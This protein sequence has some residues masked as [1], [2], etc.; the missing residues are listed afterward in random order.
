MIEEEVLQKIRPRPEEEEKLRRVAERVLK[1]LEGLDARLEGSFRKGTWLSGDVDL[2][3]FV[4]FPKDLGKEWLKENALKVLLERL[5]KY[6]YVV[7]YA[8]HP[9]L[10]LNVDGV[11]VEVVPALKV[12]S[13]EEAITPV[14]RTP[15]HTDFV[16]RN[17][18]PE[19]R[20]EVRLLK[21]FMKGI[22]VYGAEIK[23]KGFSGYVAELLVYF[24]GSFR[25]VVSA[26]TGW[27]PPVFIPTATPKREFKE[28]LIIPDP[29]DPR[30]NT[31]SAVSLKRLAEFV[32]AS[33][34]Y[35]KRPS[36]DFFFPPQGSRKG[37]LRGDVLVVRLKLLEDVVEDTIWGQIYRNLDTLRNVLAENHFKVMDLGAWMREKEVFIAVQLES[38][39]I[40]EWYLNQGPPFYD[41]R[42]A[43]DFA[44]KND[45]VWVGEDGRL[46]AIKKRRNPDARELVVKTLKFRTKV[47]LMGA[48]WVSEVEDE[49][50]A[51][52]LAKRPF[53]LT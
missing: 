32:L 5:S 33:R 51:E 47:E 2:D 6:N 29:V 20:D 21:K 14:D 4:F 30:R 41:E 36:I 37:E 50:L 49:G 3:V 15:F 45:Y 16:T 8:D 34:A 24:Y 28:P 44:K 26:A 38:K 17:L 9:Y 22:G 23:V 53:W 52:F 27:K 7:S 25:N 46:Y 1:D 39:D 43:E 31:A 48:E 18:T 11:H 10:T 13:G 40:G 12:N 42:A 19:Q 35:I